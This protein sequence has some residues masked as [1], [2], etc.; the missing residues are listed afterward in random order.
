MTEK[1][2]RVRLVIHRSWEREAFSTPGTREALLFAAKRIEAYAKGDA[3]RRPSHRT[4][5]NSIAK[6]IGSAVAM[7]KDG[8]YGGVYTE[9]N[10]RARHAMLQERGFTSPKGRKIP[11]RRWLKGALLKARIDE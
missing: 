6:Q 2:A 5:W 3:P 11:G 4:A 8:W 10:P 7:D 9:A 1:S